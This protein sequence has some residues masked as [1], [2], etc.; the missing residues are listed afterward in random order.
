LAQDRVLGSSATIAFYGPNGPVVF[1]EVDGFKATRK[2]TQKQF[3]PLGQ[4]GERTQDIYQGWTFD[5][6]GAV[7]DPSYDDIVDQIDQAALNGQKNMRFR[8]TE[9]IQYYDGTTRTWVYPD[10]VLFGFDKDI[11]AANSEIKWTFKGEAQTRI[12]G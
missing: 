3:Q 10:A 11:S 6:H 8:V 4:V 9:T 1:A 5:C 7:I 12:P 2:S